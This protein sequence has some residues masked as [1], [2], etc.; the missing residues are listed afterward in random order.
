L[1]RD[2]CGAVAVAVAVALP[3]LAGLAGLA[4]EVGLWFAVQ[5]QNQAAADATAYSAALEYAAQLQTGI[6]TSPTTAATTTAGYNLFSNAN[7]STSGSTNCT[8][9]PC[10]GYTVGSTCD[11]S[12][13]SGT[14]NAPLNAVQVALTQPLNTGLVDWVTAFFAPTSAHSSPTTSSV[15]ITTTAIAAFPQ[16]STAC[17]LALEQS[18]TGISLT[19]NYSLT[20]PNCSVAADSTSGTAIDGVGNGCIEAY[21]MLSPGGY[22]FTG[23]SVSPCTANGYDLTS[24]PKSKSVPNP[25]ATTLTHTFLSN[26]LPTT[27]CGAPTITGAPGAQTYTYPGNCD[28]TGGVSLLGNDNI[29]LSGGTQI[30]GGLSLTGNGTINLSPGTYWI[31]DGSLTL[32]GNITL[33]CTS[34]SPGGPGVT[35]IFTTTK[36]SSGTIGT[37]LPTGNVTIDL[38]APASGTYAGYL[39]LQDTVTG[40]TYTS[41]GTVGNASSTLSGLIYFPSTN[42]NFVG[43]IQTNAS[44][45]LVAVADQF[46]L[47]GNIGL[48][49]SGCKTAGLTTVPELLSVYLAL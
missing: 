21:T 25:Y 1:W 23:N 4:I 26:G 10:Y 33:E 43:N 17:L 35:I 18:G 14:L 7:C 8:L 22:S 46:S 13:A 9:Y 37:L 47:T 29:N 32:V 42:L 30:A 44:S 41:G 5:R 34:C 16:T 36:G 27:S 6:T 49:D 2:R 48:D 39:L 19:G 11:T 40:A 28:I 38:N 31:T 20:M 3:V 45:C 24:P 15:T 12:S